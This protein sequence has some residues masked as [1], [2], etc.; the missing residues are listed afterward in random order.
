[1]IGSAHRYIYMLQ[2]SGQA[3]IYSNTVVLWALYTYHI[4]N[5]YH[6]AWSL[7]IFKRE[8]E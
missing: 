3:F 5:L 2:L 6:K 1:M 4:E 8:N 7:N